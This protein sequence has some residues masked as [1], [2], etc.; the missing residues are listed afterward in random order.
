MWEGSF[1]KRRVNI[2]ED[3]ARSF[4]DF[5]AVIHECRQWRKL[6]G[7]LEEFDTESRLALKDLRTSQIQ[8]SKDMSRP[9]FF[10]EKVTVTGFR[11][12]TFRKSPHD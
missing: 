1:A 6:R 2:I 9:T 8:N 5:A 12:R 11:K 3:Q 4:K 10:I 7:T